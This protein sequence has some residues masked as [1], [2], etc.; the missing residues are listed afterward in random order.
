LHTEFVKTLHQ[1]HYMIPLKNVN[2]NNMLNLTE[3]Y[4]KITYEIPFT[5]I[6]YKMYDNSLWTND[7]NQIPKPETKV[8]EKPDLS[9]DIRFDKYLHRKLIK[10]QVCNTKVNNEIIINDTKFLFYVSNKNDKTTAPILAEFKVFCNNYLEIVPIP[11]EINDGQ[12]YI[13]IQHQSQEEIYVS[14]DNTELY[15][16][17][18]IG[19]YTHSIYEGDLYELD[20]EVLYA[21]LI[22]LSHFD[23]KVTTKSTKLEKHL[24]INGTNI[25]LHQEAEKEAITFAKNCAKVLDNNCAIIISDKSDNDNDDDDEPYEPAHQIEWYKKFSIYPLK[26]FSQSFF[27][28]M[29]SLITIFRYYQNIKYKDLNIKNGNRDLSILKELIC[30][31]CDCEC[32][33]F[34]ESLTENI[35]Y[36]FESLQ[37]LEDQFQSIVQ[38]TQ[39]NPNIWD[40]TKEKPK[41]YNVLINKVHYNRF[42]TPTISYFFDNKLPIFDK[43]LPPT[44]VKFQML[45]KKVKIF[46]EK[47]CI[48][49]NEDKSNVLMLPCQHLLMC[50]DCNEKNYYINNTQEQCPYNCE[51]DSS[52]TIYTLNTKYQ[53]ENLID[54]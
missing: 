54:L 9:A 47:I 10:S 36:Y 13:L 46:G 2:I 45:R 41:T 44:V 21:E 17:F 38:E 8:I 49:C 37:Y 12:I 6:Q 42:K 7:I 52:T 26:F 50:Y 22:N 5:Q 34:K 31:K 20:D 16:P 25:E 15:L 27:I 11:L 35:D 51:T 4:K 1:C 29:Y 19:I 28:H 40:F 24:N 39:K 32:N 14:I 33:F 23:I 43:K 48:I 53:K 30:N 18:G 3:F